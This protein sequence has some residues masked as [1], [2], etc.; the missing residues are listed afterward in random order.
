MGLVEIFKK[1]KL[2]L[3]ICIAYNTVLYQ[4]PIKHK[5]TQKSKLTNTIINFPKP[6]P[7]RYNL[8]N[9][10][11][12]DL[13]VFMDADSICVLFSILFF[14]FYLFTYLSMT[15]I[16]PSANITLSRFYLPG[17][18]LTFWASLMNYSQITQF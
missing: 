14:M 4:Y 9:C 15:S 12:L 7:A 18:S 1:Q 17:K 16:T 13:L 3:I 5:Q 11:Y 2:S 8:I 10:G 6:N